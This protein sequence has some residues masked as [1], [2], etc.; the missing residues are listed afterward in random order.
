MDR[1]LLTTLTQGALGGLTFGIYHSYVTQQMMAK[2]NAKLHRQWE[3]KLSK[4]N[5]LK[6]RGKG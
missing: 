5:E 1:K 4:G 3:D 2:H 6:N